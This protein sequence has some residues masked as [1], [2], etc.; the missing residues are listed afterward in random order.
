MIAQRYLQPGVG[1]FLVVGQ[2]RRCAGAGAILLGDGRRLEELSQQLSRDASY[3][4]THGMQL[5]ENL[6]QD[7][8]RNAMYDEIQ[9]RLVGPGSVVNVHPPGGWRKYGRCPGFTTIHTV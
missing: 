3:A 4:E 9:G 2:H 8:L 6:S 7:L 1:H 5:S